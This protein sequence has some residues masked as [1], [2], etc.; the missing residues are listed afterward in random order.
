MN[1]LRKIINRKNYNKIKAN[2][3][4]LFNG[5]FPMMK[6]D[7][8]EHFIKYK[9]IHKGK[10]AILYATG[11]SIQTY[12]P[13][14]NSKDYIHIGVNRIYNYPLIIEKLNYYFFGSEYY[15]DTKHRRAVDS[16]SKR[17]DIT[18]FSS[19]FEEGISHKIINRG[20]ISPEDAR[21]IDAF[22]F[23]NNLSYFTNNI[24]EY[25]L[26]GH[27]IVFPSLQFILYTGI[28]ELYLVGCDGGFMAKDKKN[29]GEDNLIY[30]WK[31]FKSFKEK[32]YRNVSMI[33]INPVSLK[34]MFNDKI[35]E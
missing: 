25:A 23:E 24:A 29:H 35:I 9:D 3:T 32:Y 7:K 20:N 17:K 30:W 10:S 5:G 16:I 31:K 27:S 28:K 8:N 2:W 6:S 22:P 1:E 18:I 13:I 19:S 4:G 11:P 33:S 12:R 26:L 21:E 34:G 15:I 14:G